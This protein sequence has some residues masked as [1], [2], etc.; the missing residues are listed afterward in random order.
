MP[1]DRHRAPRARGLSVRAQLTLSYAAF[2]ITVGIMLFGVGFL[3]LRFV[4]EG[5]IST[6]NGGFAP[7][8]SDLLRV[9]V[10]YSAGAL[11]LLAALGLGGGWLLAGRMVRPLQ[12]ITEAARLARDG[13]L[14]HRINMA[15][16]HNE[17]VE[18]ADVF[19][20]M[21]NR[22]HQTV[23]EQRRFAANASHELRTPHTVIR[24]ML[25][26]A[27]ADLAGRDIDTVL[28]RVGEMN[29]RS[30]MLTEALLNLAIAENHPLELRTV[31]LETLVSGVVDE[32]RDDAAAARVGIG[33]RVTAQEVRGDP[34]LLTQLM[35][36]LMQNAIVHNHAGGR[37]EVSTERLPDGAAQLRVSNTGQVLHD[38]DLATFTEPFVRG[39]GRT[40]QG[41][42]T[43]S[44]LGLAIVAAI[45][46]AHAG[47]VLLRARTSGGL[48]VLVT[49]PP[50]SG[51]R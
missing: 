3:V 26:I 39:A 18:L 8:R 51:P 32:L 50:V 47:T 17:L 30:I 7:D 20:D 15:G 4:P 6:V 35:M 14:D 43:G 36:N 1:E 48:H 45:V 5:A 40:R 33:T 38:S 27:Q 28:R 44:G 31:E 10:R 42:H 9:F 23:E 24:T 49:F 25:E 21:L 19:D 29:E 2:V 11:V 22:V 12:R 34:A 37:I 41:L 13:S 46:R 16:R